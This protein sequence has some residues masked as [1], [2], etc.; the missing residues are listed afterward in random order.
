M[1]ARLF[2]GWVKRFGPEA[3]RSL[4]EACLEDPRLSLRVVRGERE[5]LAEELRA[6]GVATARG[7]HPAILT[8]APE[9][10]EAALGA[11]AFAQG[12]LTV[13]G[14]SAL[15]AAELC[16]AS[17]G[18]RWL[19]LCA[20]PGGKTAVLAACGAAVVACDVS[21]EK[22]LRLRTTLARL[23]LG[24]QVETRLLVG[25]GP[26][27]SG[28]F[29]GALVDAPC[30]NT[31]VLARR[32]E[33]RWRFGP[34]T[35]KTLAALQAGLLAQAAAQVRPGGV[36]VYSTCSIEPDENEQR[37]RGFIEEHGEWSLERELTGFPH[38]TSPPGPV[39]GGFAA[40]RV[41]RG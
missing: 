15:R 13:Q 6:C 33:A 39:D 12:R 20:A 36:L 9:D 2:K 29:D 14:E 10:L 23:G 41:R 26:L 40:R 35:R 21:E 37:V 17:R 25:D 24:A 1:P 38:P 28:E 18:E 32:P 16:G 5:A 11:E 27:E 8:A 34:K 4:A 7:Q 19:D 22:L 30:S 3:A 31:G